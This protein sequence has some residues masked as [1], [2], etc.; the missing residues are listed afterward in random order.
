MA[1]QP[2]L[3]LPGVALHIV[4]RG[5]NR[6]ACFLEDSD[7]LCYLSALRQ[8]STKY[9]SVVHAYCLMTNH[10]HLLMTPGR[11][12]ACTNF[13][14]DLGLR[15]VRYF[16]R[17]HRRTGTLWEGRYRSC[18][19]ESGHYVVACYR[20]IELNPVRAGIVNEPLSYPWS[21]HA[22]N[23]G[24]AADTLVSPHCEY[25]ALA[26]IHERCVTAYKQLFSEVI[27]EAEVAAIRD[28]TSGGLPLGSES[29]RNRLAAEGK[30]IVREKPGPRTKPHLDEEGARQLKIV[31]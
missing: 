10:V 27:G 31:L 12:E 30:R 23:V 20:Y 15:Y 9:D 28:A 29:L 22:A 24:L 14:R 18:I 2:R 19:V 16:N 3:V 17:R 8:L 11:A 25:L 13:M 26:D 6:N 21:S 5:N 4:Q 7:Y 1:R